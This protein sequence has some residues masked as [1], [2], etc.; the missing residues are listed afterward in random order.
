MI[1]QQISRYRLEEALGAGGM[2]VVYRA[3]DLRLGRSVAIKL[4]PPE[5]A[6]NKAALE[7]FQREARVASALTDPAICTIHDIDVH[8][9]RPF[10]VMELLEGE[11]LREVLS[12][13]PLPLERL[14]DLAT[15]MAQGL[16]AAHRRGIVHRDVKPANVFVVQGDRVK[17]LDFGLAKLA[18]EATS[19]PGDDTLA[20]LDRLSPDMTTR[21]W[22][23]EGTASYMSP[24]QAR[25]ERLDARSDLF[26]FGAVLYEMATGRPAF[27][28]R[29]PAVVFD[30]V[31]N[32]EP[33]PARRLNPA[34]PPELD[35]ILDKALE[36]DP[37]LR[38]QDAADLLADLRRLARR[39]AT[40]A[41]AGRGGL[42]ASRA[43]WMPHTAGRAVMALVA[44]V[45]ALI[46]I[47]V[48]SS[49]GPAPLI[50]RDSVLLGEI[51]NRTDD[52]V[53]DDTIRQA[54]AVQLNQSPF[55]DV[56]AEERIRETLDLMGRPADERLTR[57][58]A[59]EVCQRQDVKA[60]LAGSIA[61]LGAL[62]VITLEATDCRQGESIAR[63]QAEVTGKERVLQAVGALASSMR[64]R[65]GE[66]LASLERYDV[67]VEQA[68]TPSLE[69]L[70]SYTRG[71][72]RRAGG[73]E[74][75]AIPFFER[76]I[77]LD[78]NFA[79]AHA[80]LSSI[81]GNLGESGRS[82]EYARLA[83]ARRAH[84]SERERLFIT[85]QYHD[86][87]TGDQWQSIEALEVWKESFPRDYR[88][89]NALALALMRLGQYDRAADEAREAMR[90]NPAHPFPYSNLAHALRGA[91]RYDEAKA[92]ADGAV[93]RGIETLPTRRLLYQLAV[94]QQD[95][96]A[97]AG[98]VMWGRDRAR[99]FDLVGATAQMLAFGGRMGQARDA[100]RRTMDLAARQDVAEVA[101][102]YA[103]QAAW[104]ELLYG[105]RAIAAAQARAVLA[106]NPGTTPRLRAAAVLALAGFPE[107]ARPIVDQM[108]GRYQTDTFISSVFLPIARAAIELAR[109]PEAAVEHLRAAAPLELGTVAALVPAYLRGAAYLAQER[110]G[111]AAREFGKVLQHRGVDPFSP[112]H[113][114]AQLGLARALASAGRTG[115]SREAYEAFFALWKEA[116]E[117]LRLL[118]EAR[119][120]YARSGR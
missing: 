25:A 46:L 87:I 60:M 23:A 11:S 70:R 50:E 10:I 16:D 111:E 61:R 45:L 2:G 57:G 68:T 32:R 95:E 83:Y 24:E 114:A 18:V 39:R 65:L 42:A 67:P 104:T 105:E 109:R 22:A 88:P 119:A 6:G 100:Y 81:F 66:S 17:M 59:L 96:E 108:A 56:V 43:A 55:L 5:L 44:A 90:R 92:A 79:L 48:L 3:V 33:L 72:A 52:L 8:D 74:I 15:Q 29:T 94:M 19:G 63:E 37:V 115:E 40:A 86:R 36:K 47:G 27:P 102:G 103:A 31:L 118:R 26:S 53:F 80:M 49:R 101:A 62:Y 21:T 13:G 35:Q 85:V 20:S 84:V 30:A 77:E 107:E 41:S 120:E 71:I 75:E 12:R 91:G 73:A 54:L 1:G 51:E 78:A 64:S 58:V 99:E 9:G 98:H 28:G 106:G 93:A 38:Y 112:F 4:L 89:A 116:D 14:L 82:E 7:R 97:A 76:A 69:A 110:P 34:V 117:D 113:P